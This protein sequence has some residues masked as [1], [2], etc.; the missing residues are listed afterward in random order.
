[1]K[2]S[3]D[4]GSSDLK[5]DLGL[6]IPSKIRV[7]TSLNKDA[8]RVNFDDVDYIIGE[9]N[10]EVEI[11]KASREH[12]L[13]FIYTLIALSTENISNE[14]A[15]GLP[16]GQYKSN[17]DEYKKYIMANNS[18]TFM[19]NGKIRTIKITDVKVFPEGLASV[20]VGYN[21]VVVDIGGRTTDIC[22]LENRKVVNPLTKAKGILN[23]YSDIVN[24]ANE[25]YSLDLQQEEG[26]RVLKGLT[27]DGELVDNKFAKDIMAEFVD[28]IVNTLK[29]N[30]SI[31]TNNLLLTGGGAEICERAFKNR[32]KQTKKLENATFSNAVAF[33]KG[34][35]E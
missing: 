28:D 21:G 16:L 14:I 35:G 4:I 23:L 17:K 33:R 5:T 19:I 11:N 31:K 15:V 7:G 9:G 1:M 32:I 18:K 29:L 27:V 24:F 10:R 34:L 22:L 2:L 30:Y 6:K 26:E 20:P 3:L 13:I 8:I 25:K 12:N